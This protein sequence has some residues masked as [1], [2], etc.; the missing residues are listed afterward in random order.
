MTN[1]LSKPFS[2][3]NMAKHAVPSSVAG[4][5]P[6]SVHSHSLGRL[7]ASVIKQKKKHCRD[8]LLAWHCR[9]S[10]QITSLSH[11]LHNQINLHFSPRFHLFW[12]YSYSAHARL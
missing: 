6:C 10:I 5:Q 11:P 9:A 7:S 1:N 8:E 4:V 12:P 2:I 3:R